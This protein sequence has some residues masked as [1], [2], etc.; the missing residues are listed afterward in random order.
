M[1]PGA[2]TGF[3]WIMDL[4]GMTWADCRLL[5]R[6]TGDMEEGISKDGTPGGKKESFISVLAD[7]YPQTLGN[8]IM[9]RPP[10]YITSV[11]LGVRAFMDPKTQKAYYFIKTP[12]EIEDTLNK[13][14]PVDTSAWIRKEI[15]LVQAEKIQDA[16]AAGK[17]IRGPNI[18]EVNKSGHD[19]RAAPEYVQRF[20]RPVGDRPS[21]DKL[22]RCHPNILQF[23]ETGKVG[24]DSI[25]GA[26]ASAI[27]SAVGVADGAD[28]INEDGEEG[29]EGRGGRS[30][31]GSGGDGG[32]STVVTGVAAVEASS[33]PTLTPKQ[34]REEARKIIAL[35]MKKIKLAVDESEKHS[36][37]K[38]GRRKKA[39][40]SY[41][42]I[43]RLAL[44]PLEDAEDGSNVEAILDG[45]LQKELAVPKID[46]EDE[47]EDEDEEEDEEDDDGNTLITL[48]GAASELSGSEVEGTSLDGPMT[49]KMLR[50]MRRLVIPPRGYHEESFLVDKRGV[51]G[52]TSKLGWSFQVWKRAFSF[53]C[54]VRC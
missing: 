25:T 46:E 27:L 7:H 4:H 51:A 44:Q 2:A 50:G 11:W 48:S 5:L 22:H 31:G 42:Q 1:E 40:L 38:K 53:V 52:A 12:T 29:G 24:V 28:E 10:V 54:L 47:D 21:K 6:L 35:T 36:M 19:S 33:L 49:T 26:D 30:G 20:C 39:G 32:G 9:M 17:T 41:E 13:L 45:M 23:M 15:G 3:T 37:R 16:V 8:C 14:F 18:W 34:E 43:E